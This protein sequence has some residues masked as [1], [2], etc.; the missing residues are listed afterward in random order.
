MDGFYKQAAVPLQHG[1]LD[2]HS[3]QLAP[4]RRA[5]RGGGG[6][7]P[8]FLRSDKGCV[9]CLE[10]NPSR[11]PRLQLGASDGEER[12]VEVASR[13]RDGAMRALRWAR[14]PLPL[15]RLAV[16]ASAWAGGIGRVWDGGSLLL[17]S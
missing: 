15:A 16:A 8:A 3:R 2:F 6:V 14:A 13:P 10:S 17:R 4:K 5:P 1:A 11:A 12:L 9:L 7:F